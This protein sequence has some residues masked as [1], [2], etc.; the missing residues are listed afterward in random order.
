ME[1]LPPQEK[2]T[3]VKCS[4]SFWHFVLQS[5]RSRSRPDLNVMLP[6]TS[7]ATKRRTGHWVLETKMKITSF[8]GIFLIPK[9]FLWFPWPQ[10]TPLGRHDR[11]V[12]KIAFLSIYIQVL[13]PLLLVSLCLRRT[14]QCN[15]RE[16]WMV[17]FAAKWTS[18]PKSDI[19]TCNLL[20]LSYATLW[21]C[22]M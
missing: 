2:V 1:Q 13:R 18:T 22:H 5:Q 15:V 8:R 17:W 16:C 9:P 20:T 11:K 12:H 21:H 4:F 10:H 3:S 7:N 14:A 6:W 19:F